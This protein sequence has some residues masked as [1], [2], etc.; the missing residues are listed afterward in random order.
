MNNNNFSNFQQQQQQQLRMLQQQQQ[1]Q[2]DWRAAISE[3]DR[4]PIIEKLTSIMADSP[5]AQGKSRPELFQK[6]K[7]LESLEFQK[8][9]TRESY[10]AQMTMMIKNA[11]FKKSTI[12]ATGQPR[13]MMANPNQ[14]AMQSFNQ[15][16]QTN[17]MNAQMAQQGQFA[18]AQNMQPILPATFNPNSQ[19]MALLTQTI[20]LYQSVGATLKQKN[21]SVEMKLKAFEASRP[22]TKYEKKILT[23]N[24]KMHVNSIVIVI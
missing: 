18:A 14:N 21:Q 23:P 20:A 2:V 1:Q 12:T 15:S 9:T 8:A 10:L 24:E 22:K 19:I 5:Y 16:H 17:L 11:E 4:M 7:E 6:M 13:P 3:K